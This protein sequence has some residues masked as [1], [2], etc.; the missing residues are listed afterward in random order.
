MLSRVRRQ[1]EKRKGG[2]ASRSDGA[3]SLTSASP[4]DNCSETLPTGATVTPNYLARTEDYVAASR[5]DLKEIHTFGWVEQTLMGA[6]MF[7]CSGAS[8]QTVSIFASQTDFQMT[9]WAAS[10]IACA[11]LGGIAMLCGVAI[12]RVK[13][14]KIEKYFR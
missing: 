10:C 11:I 2:I 3:A 4:S 6:G 12:F 5:A 8:W 9:A 13:Q 7:F 1:V 14:E